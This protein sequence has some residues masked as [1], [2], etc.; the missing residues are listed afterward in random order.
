MLVAGKDNLFVVVMKRVEEVEKF[1]LRL[2]RVGDELHVIHA[3]YIVLAVLVFKTVGT[4]GAH[5]VDVIY[6]KALRGNVQHLLVCVRFLEVV[7]HRL[8]EMRFPVTSL[9][10][11]EERIVC[12]TRPFEY[13]F[14][15]GVRKLVEWTHA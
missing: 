4:A 7:P 14:C 15:G 9:S 13:R 1:L 2:L 5:R 3:E 12:E 8:Y 6:R 10:I 11:N